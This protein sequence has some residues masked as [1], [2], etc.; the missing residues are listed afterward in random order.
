[1]ETAMIRLTKTERARW[2]RL[3]KQGRAIE[4][5]KIVH[6]KTGSLKAALAWANTNPLWRRKGDYP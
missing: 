4:A 1:M 5:L 2:E 6:R 3:I